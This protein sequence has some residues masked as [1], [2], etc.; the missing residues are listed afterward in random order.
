MRDAERVLT[1]FL[2]SYKDIVSADHLEHKLTA[3]AQA[4]VRAGLFRRAAVQVYASLYGEK[5]FGLAGLTPEEEEWLRAHDVLPEE[6]YARVQQHGIRIEEMYY[7]PHDRLR[8]VLPNMEDFLLTDASISREDWRE[9]QWHPDDM[10]Y[11]PLMASAG[12]PLGN[13]TADAPFDSRVPNLATAALLAPF[14]AMAAATVEQELNRRR[15]YMTQCFNGQFFR[16]EVSRRMMST[17]RPLGL[18]FVDMNGLKAVN[19]RLGHEAGDRAIQDTAVALRTLVEALAGTV[20][21]DPVVC[22]LYGDEFGVLF[23]PDPPVA[24]DEVARALMEAW[25]PDVP[26]SSVGVAVRLPDDSPRTLVRRAEERMYAAKRT[27]R[28]PGASEERRATE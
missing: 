22:R 5:L 12:Y 14:V 24:P 3:I 23:H 8:R 28:P 15:D 16:D 25:P 4:L 9:G 11:M 7:V 10:L 13:I 6:E 27:M 1:V 21:R 2:S 19:D 26:P 18:V 17:N 20:F